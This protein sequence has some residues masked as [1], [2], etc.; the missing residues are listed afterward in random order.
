MSD[1]KSMSPNIYIKTQTGKTL[2]LKEKNVLMTPKNKREQKKIRKL[3][4]KIAKRGRS[5]ND[6]VKIMSF[7]RQNH[8]KLSTVESILPDFEKYKVD[9]PFER[10]S[11]PFCDGIIIHKV[12][13]IFDTEERVKEH[14]SKHGLHVFKAKNSNARN[15]NDNNKWFIR[16]E[17][18]CASFTREFL[19]RLSSATK[20]LREIS[21]R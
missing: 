16:F 14:M 18:S 7:I 13:G 10:I 17:D 5:R 21:K 9:L 12:K 11:E 19:V 1:E 8:D 3:Q 2:R 6:S 15:S 20:E 4:Y